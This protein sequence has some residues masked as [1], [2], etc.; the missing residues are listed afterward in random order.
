MFFSDEKD[1][2]NRSPL[3]LDQVIPCDELREQ[4][5]AWM[6]ENKIDIPSFN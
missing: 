4:I 2:F 5:H 3:R 6:A 1:P